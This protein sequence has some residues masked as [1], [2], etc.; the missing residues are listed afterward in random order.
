M[1]TTEFMMIRVGDGVNLSRN[2]KEHPGKMSYKDF[3][4]FLL[5]EEDKQHPTR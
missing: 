4:W 5:A 3:V 2:V 1:H